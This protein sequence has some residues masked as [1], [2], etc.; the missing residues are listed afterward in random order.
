VQSYEF[1]AL[2]LGWDGAHA[3]LEQRNRI[4]KGDILEILSPNNYFQSTVKA[5]RILDMENNELECADKVQQIIKLPCALPLSKNDILR[6]RIS[7][8]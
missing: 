6:K 7:E 5:E 4:E 2:C 3:I 1:S 8:K